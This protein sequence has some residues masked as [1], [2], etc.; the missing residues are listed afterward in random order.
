MY[1][2]KASPADE[3]IIGA[4]GGILVKELGQSSYFRQ[5]C[6]S[7]Y[8]KDRTYFHYLDTI[9]EW[10]EMEALIQLNCSNS[11]TK[12]SRSRLI[13]KVHTIVHNDE[14]LVKLISSFCNISI[15]NTTGND[16]SV[17]T[18]VPPLT[19]IAEILFNI[20]LDDIDREIEEQLPKLKYARFEHEIF[21]PIFHK[22]QYSTLEALN[23][24]FDECNFLLPTLQHA[25]RG[26]EPIPFSGGFILI[27]NEGKSQ[28]Q[29]ITD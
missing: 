20:I 14:G 16:C 12:F 5:S 11:I 21:I 29:L 9:Q 6:Y 28:I 23:K 27:N 18:G 26:G 17:N 2:L 24:I 19:F 1:E 7:S 15:I 4:L 3:V 13:E 22:E 8:T 25:V 10:R